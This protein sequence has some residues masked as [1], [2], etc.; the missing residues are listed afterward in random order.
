MGKDTLSKNIIDNVADKIVSIK[1][2]LSR[3]AR[4]AALINHAKTLTAHYLFQGG[5]AEAI[6]KAGRA[7]RADLSVGI[8]AE[9]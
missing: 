1:L 6:I 2:S 5:S 8:P 7:R 9:K 4:T 3:L